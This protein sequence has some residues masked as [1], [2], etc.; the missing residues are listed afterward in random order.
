MTPV[1]PISVILFPFYFLL[2][3]TVAYHKNNSYIAFISTL[4]VIVS[5]DDEG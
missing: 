5:G 1:F 4:G 2:V 3:Y